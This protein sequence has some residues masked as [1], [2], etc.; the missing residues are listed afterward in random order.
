MRLRIAVSTFG[1]YLYMDMDEAL[2]IVVPAFNEG[3]T[4]D[5]SLEHIARELDL[6][7]V[8]YELVLIDDGSTDGTSASIARAMTS[9]GDRVLAFRHPENRGLAAALRTGFEHARNPFVAVLDADLSYAPSIVG[10]DAG[11]SSG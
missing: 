8:P 6:L 9:L 5:V 10:G 4:F 3:D 7:A 11:G 1:D 2:S